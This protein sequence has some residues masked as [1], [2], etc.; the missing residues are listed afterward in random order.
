MGADADFAAAAAHLCEHWGRSTAHPVLRVATP[1]MAEALFPRI[2]PLSGVLV[3]GEGTAWR[4]GESPTPAASSPWHQSLLRLKR[5]ALVRRLPVV[6]LAPR[7][8]EWRTTPDGH[9][10]AFA[11][12]ILDVNQPFYEDG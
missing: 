4:G 2:T 5:I 12:R 9:P 11:D 8:A 7:L 1:A 10:S 3:S 6:A